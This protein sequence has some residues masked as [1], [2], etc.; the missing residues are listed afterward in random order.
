MKLTTL[1]LMA[2][3]APS[4]ATPVFANEY[5]PAMSAYLD[6]EIRNWVHSS[7]LVDAINAQHVR[8]SEYDQGMIDRLD[9]TWRAEIGTPSTP[10]ITPV[11]ENP[12]ADFLREQVQASDGQIT[13]ITI[14]D[15][16]GLNVASS[17]INSDM[18]QGDEV[19][20]TETYSIG[21]NAV[22]LGDVELEESTRR[23]QAQISLT[24]VD[25]TSG[26]PIGA[27]VVGVDAESLI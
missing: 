7:I 13:E 10:T 19:K 26:L 1:A 6:A 3:I 25:P 8:T 23:Y 18:W 27:I 14:I 11:L 2:A 20:F 21:P 15:S 24:I 22:H 9:L 4:I 5:A 12:A 17:G 16:V